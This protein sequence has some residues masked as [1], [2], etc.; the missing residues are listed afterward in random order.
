M[1][2]ALLGLSN[3]IKNN[4]DKIQLWSKSFKKYCNDPVILLAANA[5][6]EELSL[7]ESIGIQ[8]VKVTISD[9]ERIFH[10]RLSCVRDYLANTDIDYLLVTDV[11]D[12]AF[13]SDPFAKLNFNDYDIAVSGEGVNI[14]NEPWNHDN[15]KRLF[16]NHINKCAPNEVVCSGVIAGKREALIKLYDKMFNLCESSTNS[17]NIQDQAALIVILYADNI[18]I[19]IKIFNL[20]EGWTM[21]CAVAGPT[22]FFERW[23]F[24]NTIKYGIPVMYNGVVCTSTLQPFDIVHQFNRTPQWH[25]IIKSMNQL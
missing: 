2:K 13:Q 12:V 23:N 17:H 10:K 8:T 20:D 3:N 7:C 18:D 6:D 19:K 1:K 15:I 16:P 4:F 9:S 5:S 11:F 25:N 14:D 21:H 22:E 24:K